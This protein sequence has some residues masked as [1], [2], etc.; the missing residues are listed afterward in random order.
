MQR[1]PVSQLK[2]GMLTARGV[3]SDDGRKLLSAGTRITPAFVTRLGEMK[4]SAVYIINPFMEEIDL[5][6]VVREDDRVK[7]IQ[8]MKRVFGLLESPQICTTSR[9]IRAVGKKLITEDLQ[10]EIQQVGDKIVADVLRIKNLRNRNVLLPVNEIRTSESYL[11]AHSV[12]VCILSVLIASGMNYTQE[13]LRDL[14]FGTLVRDVGEMMVETGC[15]SKPGRLTEDEMEII[16]SH[17]QYGFELLRGS[18]NGITVPAMHVAFQHHEKYDGGG[19]PRGLKNL[20][21]HEYARI[22]AIADV[23]DAI[24]SDRPYRPAMLPHEAY[25]ILLASSGCHF[26]PD[27]L[28]HFLAKIAIY[29]IG[30][31]VQLNTG[32]LGTIINAYPGMA[33]RPVI[34]L[35]MDRHGRF[36]PS[37]TDLDLREHLT[38]FVDQVI[39]DKNIFDLTGTSPG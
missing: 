9:E 21:I 36:Y 26:D 37:H 31:L 3:Y 33:N 8:T 35:I 23:Y 13:R 29:P 25:E 22:V 28:P 1:I 6:P 12:D 17:S 2:Q 34:R 27:I 14:A 15:L 38:V 18:G 5:D 4:I 7:A 39:S 10:R 11:Y 16:R 24:V 30:T 32:D 19:Y 20:E